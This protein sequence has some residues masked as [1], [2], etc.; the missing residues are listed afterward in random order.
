M[1]V[2]LL[3]LV[4]IQVPFPITPIHPNW[5]FVAECFSGIINF[6]SIAFMQLSDLMPPRHRA[7]AYGVYFG[8]FMGAIAIAPFLATVMSHLHISIFGCCVKVAAL[9]IAALFLPETLPKEIMSKA[10][11][12]ASTTTATAEDPSVFSR[13]IGALVRPV[14]ELSILSRNR[15]VV[16]VAVGSFA[17]K[18]VFSADIT[19]FFYY[20][21]RELG[22]TDKDVARMMF[23]TGILGLTVQ[24]GLLKYLISL[25]G[26]RRLLVISFCSGAIHNFIYGVANTKWLIYFGLCLSPLTNINSPLLSSLASRN[27]SSTEQGRIQGALF[28]LTSVAEAIGPVFFNFMY[29]NWYIFGSGT[30]FIGGAIIFCFGTIAVSMIPP[31]T[32]EQQRHDDEEEEDE[33]LTTLT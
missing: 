32:G 13:I 21:E 15:S 2:P 33:E 9:V 17:S 16:L 3:A 24:A 25:L 28:S 23:L 7:A 5:F 12:E 20:T 31:K 1:F 8:G 10:D 22:V 4:L 6:F 26:E 19:L 18:M 29:R 11:A 14:R 30:M 27:V